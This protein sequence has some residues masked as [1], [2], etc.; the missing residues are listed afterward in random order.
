MRRVADV[1]PNAQLW[2]AG[3]GP[4]AD[5]MRLMTDRLHLG[6]SVRFLGWRSPGELQ[7]LYQQAHVFLHPSETTEFGDREGVPNALLEA[8]A[9]G[10]PPV[11]TFHGGIP[12]AVTDGIDGLLVPERSPDALAAA[13]LR[14]TANPDLLAEL[15]S[16]AVKNVAANFGLDG[17]LRALEDCYEEALSIG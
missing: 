9:T 12:E 16:M 15:S 1:W 2:F 6:E 8:M 4:L 14:L 13:V 10:L 7:S 5:E 11:A 17:R 3:D